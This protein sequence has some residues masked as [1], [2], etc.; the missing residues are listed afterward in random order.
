VLYQAVLPLGL[1]YYTIT[2]SRKNRT[3]RGGRDDIA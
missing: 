1:S 2:K 3:K